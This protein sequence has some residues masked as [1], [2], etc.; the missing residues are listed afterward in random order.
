MA[1]FGEF[2]YCIIESC[3]AAYLAMLTSILSV[4]GKKN[5]KNSSVAGKT[6]AVADAADR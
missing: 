4:Q 6:V 1:D 5:A 2:D 3:A